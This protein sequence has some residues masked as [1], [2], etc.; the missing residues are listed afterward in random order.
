L[1]RTIEYVLYMNPNKRNSEDS[2]LIRILN[3]SQRQKNSYNVERDFFYLVNECMFE[4][5]DIY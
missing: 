5:L 3:R 2:S 1:G 4:S